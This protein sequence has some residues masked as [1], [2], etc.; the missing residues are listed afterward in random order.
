MQEKK[1]TGKRLLRVLT[2]TEEGRWGGPQARI[3]LI[4][5]RLKRIGVET[6]IVAPVR[7]SGEFHKRLHQLGVRHRLLK[8]NRLTRERSILFRY[9]L[10]FLPEVARLVRLINDE[11]FDIIH[12]NGYWQ[13]KGV[14]AGWL[15]GKKTA[16]HLN[17]TVY[18]SMFYPIFNAMSRMVDG[19]ILSSARTGEC[20]LTD[21]PQRRKKLVCEIPAP[22]DTNHFNPESIEPAADII[23]GSNHIK[24]LTIGN[25]DP[26]KGIE[27]FVEM[28]RLFSNYGLLIDFF[29]AGSELNSY[30]SYKN[31]LDRK[32]RHY[33]LD[34]VRF[35]G[36]RLDI[37]S[38]LKA[39]DIY[40]CS[41]ISESSPMAVWEAMSMAK[42]IVATD[43]GDV[44]KYIQDGT[45]GFIVPV[46]N[47]G[48]L[49]EKV[50]KLVENPEL[51]SRFGG[52]ARKVAVEKLDVQFAA[53]KHKSFYRLLLEQ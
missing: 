40:V 49:A 20:Y 14:I 7:D 33:G 19:F 16:W 9:F 8:L 45:N 4:A 36:K 48:A 24:V 13:I 25:I 30:I 51:R 15:T 17:D 5:E 32:I 38:V 39:T 31:A 3:A 42:P 44:A 10:F 23:A 53:Q 11:D 12:C 41:S 21:A 34:N 1:T 26:V 37:A 43:V 50:R 29:I 18:A 52:L 2:L 22:V 46:G 47:P 6:M 28:A 27:H 35:L